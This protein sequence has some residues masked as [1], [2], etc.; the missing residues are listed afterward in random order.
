MRAGYFYP[1]IIITAMIINGLNA[2][3]DT[4]IAVKASDTTQ[5]KYV[6]IFS[7]SGDDLDSDQGGQDVSG[8][9]QSA[10]DLFA[11]TAGFHFGTARFRIRGYST[12]NMTLMINGL[13]L[14]DPESGLATFAIWGGLNDVT[15]FR[16][17]RPYLQASRYNF[18]GVGGYSHVESHAGGFRKGT[19]FSY[20]LSNRIF[21]NRLMFTHSTGMQDNGWAFTVSASRRWAEEGFVEGTFF[22]AWSYYAAAEKKINDKH[23]LSLI[24]FGAPV[25]Q[26]RQGFSIQE[27]YD[28]AGTNFYNPNWGF[29]TLPDGS[30]VKRNARVSRNHQPMFILTD[31]FNPKENIKIITSAFYS[32]GRNGYSGLNWYDAADPRPDFW[33]NLPS[34]HANTNPARA[35]QIANAWQNDVNVRQIRW[36]DFY[37]ANSK[38]LFLLRNPNGEEGTVLIGNRSK[39]IV[40]EQI[41]DR[42]Q[43]GGSFVLNNQVN[44]RLHI[45]TGLNVTISQ[46]RNYKILDDLLG[47]DF[48]LDVDQFALR[49]FNNDTLAQNDLNVP[50]RV[51]RKGDEFGYDYLIRNNHYNAFFQAEY[52]LPKFDFYGSTFLSQSSFWRDGRMI[53]GRFPENSFGKSEVQRFTNTGFKGG[54]TYKITGRHYVYTNFALFTNAP[55]S[56]DAFISPR[57]RDDVVRGLQNETVNSVDLNYQIKYP[58]LKGRVTYFRT[59]FKNLVWFRNYFHDEFRNFINYTLNGVNQLHEG[60]ELA[61]EHNVTSSLTMTVVGSFGQYIYNSRPTATVVRENSPEVLAEN[62]TIFLKNYR[63]GGMPQT[64]VSFG[65]RYN[66]KKFWWTSINVNFF[67]GIYLEPNPDRRSAEALSNFVE[68]DPQ[69]SELLNQER[70]PSNFTVDCSIGKSWRRKGSF[71]NLSANVN[72]ALNNQ[73]F[74]VSGFEQLRYIPNSPNAFPPRLVYNLGAIYNIVLSYRF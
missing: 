31:F 22:D 7:V 19:S 66:G 55:I 36:D 17:L 24:T 68:S 56:R 52:S 21:R 65:A 73:N 47:G 62:R 27:V 37:F 49:D 67:D 18:A 72:N 60:L 38:N 51:V 58:R 8:L 63:I 23:S 6:P 43:G 35:E 46:S 15:R 14:N 10:R 2:Q 20:A 70:L 16:E 4:L 5:Q 9:L 44:E 59:E 57:T 25:M 3:T 71:I 34:F 74:I 41:T 1:V 39:Y 42:Q 45:S 48:W 28:L 13:R 64:A 61:L 32:F 33:R 11:S 40:E 26:G 29:Q 54:M 53:N 50:N 30:Q 12:E 69:W